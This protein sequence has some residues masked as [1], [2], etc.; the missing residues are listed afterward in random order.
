MMMGYG[1][2]LHYAILER[3]VF[4]KLPDIPGITIQCM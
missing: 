3:H 4:T 1:L 2:Q